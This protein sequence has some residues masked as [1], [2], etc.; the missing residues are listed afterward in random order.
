VAVCHG[1][2]TIWVSEPALSAHLGHGDEL[3]DC[4]SDVGSESGGSESGGSE[5]GGSEAGGSEGGTDDEAEGGAEGGTEDGTDDEAEDGAQESAEDGTSE[6]EAAEPTTPVKKPA[7]EKESVVDA[8]QTTDEKPAV[9]KTAQGGTRP[10]QDEAHVEAQD[11]A[12]VEAHVEVLGE[13]DNRRVEVQDGTDADD[14]E[15]EIL[16][17]VDAPRANR[18]AA[19]VLPQTGASDHLALQTGAGLGL[20][21]AGAVLLLGRRRVCT[22]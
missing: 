10:A 20:L 21:A 19:T 18:P 6:E 8:K 1:D 3:G 14:D 9:D 4:D 22:S 5:A 16:G 11:E 17:V 12:H 2:Q 15:N 7:G 13:D